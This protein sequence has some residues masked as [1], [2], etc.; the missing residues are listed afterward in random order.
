MK[1]NFAGRFLQKKDRIK[2]MA[3]VILGI[4][5]AFILTGVIAGNRAELVEAKTREIQE[6]LA[7]EVF[8]FHV[9][10]DS[11]SE[12]DQEIKLVVRD[13]VLSYME[14]SMDESTEEP[15]AESTKRWAGEHLSEIEKAAD[16]VLEKHGFDYR[17]QAEV[18]TCHFPEKRYGD[19][20]F[21]CGEY[22]ALRIKLGRASGHNWWCVLY[23]NLCFIDKACAY[24]SEEGKGELREALGDEEYELVTAPSDFK[25]KWFFF[26]DRTEEK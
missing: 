17:S 16:D 9:L 13:A 11:D 6:E 1:E 26:G 8:R 22:E 10:A 18:T 3:C 19:I 21:P 5:T 20:T 23:P 2:R 12:E 15:S 7:G 4:C 25:V 24:V 14:E